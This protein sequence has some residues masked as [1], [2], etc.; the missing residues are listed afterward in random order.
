MRSPPNCSTLSEAVGATGKADEV[1]R[2][3]APAGLAVAS[4]LAVGLGNAADIDSERIRHSA[5]TA[6]RALSGVETAA[7][8]LSA[9]DLGAAAEG[10]FL[11]AYQFAE[12]KSALRHRS[13][14][15][16]R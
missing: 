11:G 10:F 1:V 8:T 2:I 15:R 13:R 3:P 4:V 5:G 16:F 12:F 6:A 7:T 14:L 9:L